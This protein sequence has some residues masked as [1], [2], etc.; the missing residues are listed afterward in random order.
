MVAAV[1]P[2]ALSL[3]AQ[4]PPQPEKPADFAWFAEGESCASHEWSSPVAGNPDYAPCYGGGMLVVAKGE[5]P[6][7]GGW[8]ARFE[9][10]VAA[11][12][13]YVLWLAATP[14]GI[15]SPLSVSVDG[16]PAV[17]VGS[18]GEGAWGP[19]TCFRWLPAALVGLS[20][21][22]HEITVLCTGRRSTDNLYYAYLDA[23][24]LQAVGDDAGQGL[25]A[26]PPDVEVGP[27]PIRNYSG[28]GSVGRFMQYWGT[29]QGG[30]TGAVTPELIALLGRCGCSA[31]CDYQAWCLAE[32]ERG[33]WDWGFY[34]ANARA[35][36]EAGLGYNVFAWLHFPPQWA[37]EGTDFVPYRCLEHGETLRQS[38]LWAPQTLATYEEYY[39]RLGEAFPGGIA[40]LRL[41][42]PTEYGELGMPVGMTNWLVPQPHVH[43]GY[44]C[45]DDYARA[46][47]RATMRGRVGDLAALNARW[48]AT[49]GSWEEV[50]PPDVVDNRAARAAAESG[51]PA[52]IHRWLDFVDWY[53]DSNIGFAAKAV[54]VARRNLPPM[55]IILSLGY[56]QEPVAN[57][58]DESRFVKR[59]AEMGVS[60]QTPGDIGYFATR[61][62]S[63]AC[64]AY[65]VPYFTE[66]P[67]SVD[68][69]RE[70][71]RVFMDAS[72][73]TQTWFD[74]PQ[75]L[76]GAR[77]LLARY[78]QHL[79]GRP[80]VCD[81]AYL[82][83]SS[84][85]WLRPEWG[86]PPATCQLAEGLR[87]RLDYEVVDELL[88][89]DGALERLGIRLLVLAE[90]D[91]L[92]RDTLEA[93][94]GW[95]RGG[96]VLL[97]AGLPALRDL[98]GDASWRERLLPAS[99][100]VTGADSPASMAEAAWGQGRELDGGRVLAVPADS[101]P[102]VLVELTYR[103]S[104]LDPAR[105]NAHLIDGLPDGV[106]STLFA[107]R[108]LYYNTSRGLIRKHVSLRPED[109]PEDAPRPARW[110]W[111]LTIPGGA[112]A[113][114]PFD[115]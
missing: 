62:V 93:L 4:G 6:P 24:A 108:A 57:A 63:T 9:A 27:M 48:G 29:Q 66:P 83:P 10:E 95:V 38:S 102:P 79:T 40:F 3:V 7:P 91:L 25:T 100:A 51:S 106:W 55:E 59:F 67:G 22:R 107:D 75:N 20:A 64:R 104:A 65:G 18:A 26:F 11:A 81:V 109:F 17:V 46:D 5:D 114:I 98:D 113:A 36:T 13:S 78:K 21:G 32:P 77:D 30:D 68:R 19:G 74:Y 94:E 44:W 49:F 31:Y 80:P 92:R 90:G 14:P 1:V 50:G 82:L 86:W 71:S 43:P 42:M 110:E 28:N 41:A 85:W 61:R 12:G 34:Q 2:L 33:R 87:D 103:M 96:G 97:V 105:A 101:L 54:E 111:D 39:R 15:G 60:A 72:N 52:A 76:D 73:G 112:I 53:M 45:G 99:V 58:N 47:F 70:V 35:L 88:V 69:R 16:S 115:R 23:L 8:A 56:G 89:R 37:E 84:W